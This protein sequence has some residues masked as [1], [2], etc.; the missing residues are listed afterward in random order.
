MLPNCVGWLKREELY[1]PTAD[2]SASV[3]NVVGLGVVELEVTN[4]AGAVCNVSQCSVLFERL[5]RP[6][7]SP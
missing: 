1:S 3:S 5:H 6:G 2:D 7:I 4:L